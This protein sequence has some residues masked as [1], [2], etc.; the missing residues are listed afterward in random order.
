[1][2][3]NSKEFAKNITDECDYVI[4]GS[5]A[6]GGTCAKVLSENGQDV[7]VLEEGPYIKTEEF[8]TSTWR[9]MKTMFRDAG[10]TVMT[11]RSIIPFIQ[12]RCVG[13]T[14]TINAAICWRTPEDVYDGWKT[15]GIEDAITYEKL[16]QCFDV[17][18]KD[19]NIHPVSESIAGNNNLLMKKGVEAL[20]WEGRYIRRNENG[21]KGS[22]QCL[23]GCPNNAKQSTNLS[24]IPFAAERGARIYADCKAETILRENGTAVGVTGTFKSNGNQ[25]F[26]ATVRA[27]KGV[28]LAASTIQTPVLLLKNKM[29]NSSGQVGKNLQCHPGTAIYGF[30]EQDV[31][32]WEGA[33]Q[34]YE[35]FHFR[36]S[37]GFKLE[38]LA[39]TPELFAVRMPGAGSKLIN[40]LAQARHFTTI[41]IPIR[42]KTKGTVG[43]LFGAPNVTFSLVDEDV[44]TM[45]EGLKATAEIMFAAGAKKV[46][47]G[48]YGMPETLNSPDE[49]SKYDEVKLSPRSYSLVITHMMGAARLH[50]DAKHGVVKPNLETHDVKNLYITDSS[51]FPTN[52][53]VNPMLTIMGLSMRACQLMLGG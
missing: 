6:A 48:V 26:Y 12:G 32:V 50:K 21:C 45:K 14:T 35:C 19:L 49:I 11:G 37:K 53:G 47:P 44:L 38:T 3:I 30:F 33:T 41:A 5:G 9:S 43:L 10:T 28:I 52:M 25:K 34:G 15:Y 31:N 39:L 40:Y 23:Q 1:M 20:G 16:N 18:E 17:I 27:K 8:N 24:Y 7:V 2:I 36:K 42:A 51:V 13:G 29:A 46:I 4:V 22:A